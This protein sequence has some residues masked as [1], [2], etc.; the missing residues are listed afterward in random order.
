PLEIPLGTSD[1]S[2]VQTTR[3]PYLD[4]LGAEPLRVLDRA[5]HRSAERNALLELLGDLFGLKLSVQLRLMDLL[6]VDV[7]F[8]PG[9]V[10]HLAFALVDFRALPPD[11]DP[12]T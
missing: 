12:G 4:T 5:S 11:D 8:P 10:L 2:A 6:N 3:N 7:H 9:P 1:F